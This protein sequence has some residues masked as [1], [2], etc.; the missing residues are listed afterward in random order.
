MKY[1]LFLFITISA[2]AQDNFN[3]LDENGKKHG[4]WK[5]V[6]KESGRPR[7]EGTFEHGS[8][9]G[10][11]TYIDDTK[12]KSVIATRTF[13]A[14]GT[15]AY[16]VFYDQNK[17]I[18]SEGKTINKLKEGEWKYYHQA[19]KS[20]QTSEFYSKGK[21]NGVRKVFYASGAIAEE[22]NYVND[23]KNGPYKK[24]TEKG[25]VLEESNYKNGQNN[26]NA[27]YRDAVGNVTA[28]GT[29]V[30]GLKKGKW[31]FYENGKLKSEQTLPVL[32]SVG[33][34]KKK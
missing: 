15:V 20:I 28:K 11:F 10:T 14:N 5:G 29:Y 30:D 13:S 1:L 31:Q 3:K 23:V 4:L 6:H 17:N 25:I 26:G 33:K 24:L 32:K 2:F 18:V 27:I 34:P 19:S 7:F 8:E 16:D 22:A 12:A 21:L 9:S